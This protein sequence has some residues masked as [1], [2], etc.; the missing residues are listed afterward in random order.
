MKFSSTSSIAKP[1]RPSRDWI[2]ILAVAILLIALGL[3]AM[4]SLFISAI[5]Y[6]VVIGWLQIGGSILQ[7]GGA[8]LF[9]NFGGFG[10]ELF[11][12]FLG[13]VLGVILISM[14]VVAGTLIALLLVIGLMLDAV[15]GGAWALVNRRPG[16]IWPLLIA[17]ASLILGLVIILNP[18]LLL[19]LLGLLVGVSLLI[20]GV[21]GLLIALEIRKISV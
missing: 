3:V 6:V 17:L 11:F 10:A 14:P 16:W 9:R 12:G 4:S 19:A 5:A 8:F 21:I 7:I 2:W 18:A 15:L 1:Q 20:R 13:L